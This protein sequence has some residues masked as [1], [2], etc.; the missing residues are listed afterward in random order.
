MPPPV[1]EVTH[2]GGSYPVLVEPG[3]VAS[4][5][6]SAE[7]FLP[8]R[9]LVVITDRTVGRA[10]PHGLDVPTLVVPPGEGSKSRARWSAL[11]DRLLEL[12][13]GRDG[14][15]IALGGGVVGDLAGFV[16][17][18]YL[19]GIPWLQVPTS[20]LAMVDASVGGKT[21]VN[22]RRGKN[23]VGAFH[24]PVA[25]LTDPAVLPT[26]HPEHLAA[27]LVEAVKHGIVA[28]APYF[29]W[30][31]AEA[32]ALLGVN[33]ER[34]AELIA[35]SVRIKA[36]IVSAD[37]RE[38]GP[39]AILNA[40]H[41]VAH[42]IERVSGYATLH[43]DAVAI[44]LVVEAALAHRLGLAGPAL[45]P[46]IRTTLQRLRRPTALAPEWRPE[47]LLEAMGHDKKV[48]GGTIRFALPSGLGTMARDHDHWTV[49]VE[50]D[51]VHSVLAGAALSASP[52]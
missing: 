7:R 32:D 15:I 28:D 48:R 5:A 17:A 6:R 14:A 24:P 37:E 46:A 12:G 11:T 1:V 21:G 40:G 16:A 49:P 51:L 29:A 43:G 9:R 35:R 19:R 38:A 39:R 13:Y 8:G 45:A 25:V 10:V 34:L 22:T 4:L 18:T 41:T 42:A 23:L 3:L 26:L 27:G 20:L 33:L 50:P 44:G 31:G 30:I 2:A 36:A 47:E 52:C